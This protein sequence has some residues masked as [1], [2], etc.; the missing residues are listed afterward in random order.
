LASASVGRAYIVEVLMSDDDAIPLDS[1][2]GMAELKATQARRDCNEVAADHAALR[3]RQM[4][5][6]DALLSGPA[7]TWQEAADRAA[8]L[9]ELYAQGAEAR[10]PRRQTLIAAVLADLKRFARP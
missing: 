9:L 8:Y 3:E 4:Q 7:S 2:R 10:D 5:F 6:E 1:H